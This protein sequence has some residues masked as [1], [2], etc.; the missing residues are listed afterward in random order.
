MHTTSTQILDGRTLATLIQE[1][2]QSY[3]QAL[4][5]THHVPVPKLCVLLIGNLAASLT[6]V[7]AKKLAC[8]KVGLKAEIIQLDKACNQQEVLKTIEELNQDPSVNGILVQLPLPSHL[9]SAHILDAIDPLKDVDGLH[10]LNAGRLVLGDPRAMLPCTPK[11]IVRMLK[12]YNIETRA[13]NVVILGR[14]AIVGRPLSILM[15]HN[16]WGGDS[17]VTLLHS[18]SQNIKHHTQNA[19]ILI[20]AAG[21]AQMITRDFL[22]QD[23]VVIDVG[24]H[25]LEDGRLCGDV[26]AKDVTGFVKALSP[27][28]GGVGPM[29]VAMVVENVLTAWSRAH[30]LKEPS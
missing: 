7:N 21:Q 22:R 20:C 5:S 11:G 29:T 26:D 30:H 9:D 25:R 8:E 6:Y 10:C 13:K 16:A 23:T 27:V 2:Q 15:S 3:L 19:D 17:N 1:Q 18:K 4:L 12:H 24:I 14:S 28:P